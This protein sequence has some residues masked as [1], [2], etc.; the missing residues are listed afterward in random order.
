MEEY[1]I[2]NPLFHWEKFC[3]QNGILFQHLE[4]SV[5]SSYHIID[6]YEVDT[7]RPE[8]HHSSEDCV[9]HCQPAVADVL[10]T[11][12]LCY[13]KANRTLEDISKLVA[14]EHPF[15]LTKNITPNG[16]DVDWIQDSTPYFP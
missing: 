2:S 9:H 8:L 1:V 16:K 5:L 4:S 13:I 10:N 11:I 14:Y 6:A 3:N 15:N 7:Q 12:M